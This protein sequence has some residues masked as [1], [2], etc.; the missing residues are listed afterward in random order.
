MRKA[1]VWT[2]SCQIHEFQKESIT[3]ST[4]RDFPG[5]SDLTPGPNPLVPEPRSSP[6][7][8]KGEFPSRERLLL[9]RSALSVGVG[10]RF[11]SSPNSNSSSR[12]RF[13]YFSPVSVRCIS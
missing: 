7:Q 6:G 11:E 2:F 12:R 8:E 4:A 10:E 9:R 3:T 13:A 5:R 1:M